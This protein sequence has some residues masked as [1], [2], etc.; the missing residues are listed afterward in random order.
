MGWTL[1]PFLR[2]LPHALDHALNLPGRDGDAAGL[3]QVC[4]VRIVAQPLLA[5][6]IYEMEH[7]RCSRCGAVFTAPAPPEALE[8][9]YDPNVGTMLAIQRYGAGLPMYRTEAWQ[10]CFGVPMPA[11]TQWELIDQ[12]SV[13]PA[14]VYDTLIT[15][16][17]QGRLHHNDDTS[18][19]VLDL[20][21]EI[22]A[23]EEGGRTGIFTTN[24]LCQAGP[25][26]IALFFTG[27]LHAGENLDQL[28]KRR[29]PGLEIPLQMCDA[30]SR[31][32]PKNSQTDTSNC[33]THARRNFVD[34]IDNYPQECRKVV[35]SIRQ[36]YHVDEQIK[37]EGL[38]DQER[39][40]R[41]QEQSGPVMEELKKWMQEQLDQKKVEPNSGLGQAISYML[42]HWKALT[43]FLHVAGA[44]LD[45]NICE[46]ALKMAILHRKNSLFYK[47]LHGAQVGDV[48]M[49]LIHTCQLNGVNPFDYLTALQKHADE[50]LQDPARWLPWNYQ[51]ALPPMES[52]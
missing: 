37:A 9:K 27:R 7:L 8:G 13:I 10:K 52:G 45:N 44:P 29:A 47:T 31:N 49:S 50:V 39:L 17:A 38:S 1:L 18:M 42:N 5:A 51:Q 15:A 4:L 20:R 11:S 35:E 6:S 21:M 12:A 19:R 32:L 22:S 2:T 43:R 28:L 36:I 40:R 41:H 24:I 23:Q 14:L 26:Q 25:N 30:L 33:L 46:R 3:G 34:Q 48:F 16:G